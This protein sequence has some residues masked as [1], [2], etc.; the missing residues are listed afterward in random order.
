MNF[1]TVSKTKGLRMIASLLAI[2]AIPAASFAAGPPKPSSLDN[3]LAVTLLIIIGA[4]LLVIVC[5]AYVLSGAAQ[6]YMQQYKQKTAAKTLLLLMAMA[7]SPS[8]FAQGEA[9]AARDVAG[10]AES[11]FFA[12]MAVITIE[13]VTIFA[14][15]YLL[16]WLLTKEKV[17][18]A[19]EAMPLVQ[20]TNRWAKIWAKM[21]SFRS[22][23]EE[24]EI[25]MDHSY[26]GIR[27][28]DN[29]LPPWWLYGF[30]VCIVF[31]GI[32]LWR[33]HVSQSA[34]LSIAEYKNAVAKAEIEKE[35]YL[36]KAASKVDENTVQM[37]DASGIASGK[38]LF[39][40]N[41]AA[42]HGADGNGSVGPNL[43]DPYWLHGGSLKDIFKTIKYGVQEKGMKPWK[44]DFSPVQLAQLA[45]FVKS[46]QGNK[47]ANPKEP[48]GELY[49]E[50]PE[51]EGVDSTQTAI[52]TN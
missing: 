22:L 37:L 24:E 12:L 52:K 9:G 30:Y 38:A 6:V 44:D 17:R 1:L 29:R 19:V 3:P 23:K 5:L 50:A 48:Q 13:L 20:R 35:A 28:L 47:V 42:C 31:A 25:V 16:R 51:G 46:I 34:P 27:E 14:M 40:T 11:A 7:V 36:A 49:V 41:C 2:L 21:N 15:L 4:L 33:Y 45:S 10:L 18:E 32:Y 39:V 43:T 8:L 26:D